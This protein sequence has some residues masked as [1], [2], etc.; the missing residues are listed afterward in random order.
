LLIES[1]INQEEKPMPSK[2]KPKPVV[3]ASIHIGDDTEQPVSKP[4]TH[5]VVEYQT[6]KP[7]ENLYQLL[8]KV[9]GT[10]QELTRLL[11]ET[12]DSTH[13]GVGGQPVLTPK[14]QA[15]MKELEEARKRADAILTIIS[16]S[17]A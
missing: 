10:I 1:K 5:S 9:E 2:A 17:N 3:P 12:E 16:N 4:S 14:Q 7:P 13:L 6:D 15:V 11:V 8:G